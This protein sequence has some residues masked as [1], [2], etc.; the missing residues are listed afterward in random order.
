LSSDVTEVTAHSELAHQFDDAAQQRDASNFG[1]WVF[2]VTEV[3]FFGGL[4]GG[5]TVYRSM[6]PQAFALGSQFMDVPIGAANTTVLICSSLT[7]A[8]AVRSAQLSQK[9]ALIW[10]L[11]GTIF[12][13]SIFLGV[14]AYEYHHKYV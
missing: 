9:K 6:Y 1:M 11:I 12:F 14:K 5:Y 7:M 10:F 13:G 4:F 8:L 3:M 2:L